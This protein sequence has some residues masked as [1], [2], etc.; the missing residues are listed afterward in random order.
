MNAI[1]S[2]RCRDFQD[3]FDFTVIHVDSYLDGLNYVINHQCD[4]EFQFYFVKRYLV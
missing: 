3:K 2:V 1:Y 4:T